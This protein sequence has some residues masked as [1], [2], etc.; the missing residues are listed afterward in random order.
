MASS[1]SEPEDQTIRFRDETAAKQGPSLLYYGYDTSNPDVLY[2]YE[3]LPS[4]ETDIVD[5][6][7]GRTKLALCGTDLKMPLILSPGEKYLPCRETLD[8][9]EPINAYFSSQ[10]HALFN[11]LKAYENLSTEANKQ[12]FHEDG[13]GLEITI[14]LQSYDIHLECWHRRIHSRRL[15]LID[16]ATLPSLSYVTK[17][18]IHDFKSQMLD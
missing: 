12:A 14:G 13:A 4:R 1:D 17:F 7:K 3:S 8:E 11:A 18:R 15:H 6:L 10:I 2:S 9:F 16:A 5:R